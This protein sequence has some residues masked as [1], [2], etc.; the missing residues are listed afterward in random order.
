MSA[1]AMSTMRWSRGSQRRKAHARGRAF[2]RT[3]SEQLAVVWPVAW[4]TC[5][6]MEYEEFL[7]LVAQEAGGV[8]REEA[9][10]ATRATLKA[11]S[12]RITAGEAEDIAAELPQPI[13]RVLLQDADERPETFGREEFLQ[14]VIAAELGV[15]DEATAERH[16]LA[17]FAAL[18]RTVSPKEIHDA[19]AQLPKDIQELIGGA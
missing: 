15:I 7:D 12:R 4:R 11:L 6:Q 16:A 8:S 17:V 19:L 10:R 18:R 5:K 1:S 13:R 14:R 2:R 3:A 9:E